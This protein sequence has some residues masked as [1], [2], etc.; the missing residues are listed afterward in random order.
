[1][2]VELG[3]VEPND[4]V[5]PHFLGDVQRVIGGL[6]HFLPALDSRVRPRRNAQAHG[7][8][9]SA[10]FERKCM[11][12]YPLAQ[13]FR[14]RDSR[15]EHRARQEQQKFLPAVSSDPVDLARLVP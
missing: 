14:E 11:L 15:I 1:M 7:P 3:A 4:A 6:E 13:P 10:A 12:L 2:F 8:L 5:A 9:E